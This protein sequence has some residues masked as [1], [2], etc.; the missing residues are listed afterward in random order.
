MNKKVWTAMLVLTVVF[1]C[2][3]YIAKIFFPQD[4]VMCIENERLVQIGNFIDNHRLIY[5]IFCAITS[6]IT[7]YLYC[8]ACCKKL[9]F[10]VK[11]IF[12]PLVLFAMFALLITKR[13]RGIQMISHSG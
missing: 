10:N 12:I 6:F 5:Y 4:F 8:G 2:F 3:L 7:Y 1:L 13:P 9:K 11:E